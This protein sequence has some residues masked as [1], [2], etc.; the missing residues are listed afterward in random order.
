MSRLNLKTT[1]LLALAGL[2]I[3]P[4]NTFAASRGI[5]QPPSRVVAFGD[6]DLRQKAGVITLY[7]RIKSAAREVCEPLDEINIKL[8]REGYQCRQNAVAHAV[9][10]VNS[11]ALTNYYL[12]KGKNLASNQAQ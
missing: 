12:G 1:F 8:L 11:Q 2:A 9:A 6:L 4:V 5:E 7:S 3:S 10:E